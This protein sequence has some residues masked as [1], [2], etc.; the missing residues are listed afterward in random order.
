M[1]KELKAKWLEKLRSG[2]YKQTENSL[3]LIEE[4]ETFSYC[5]LGVLG[6]CLIDQ[7]PINHYWNSSNYFVSKELGVIE[8]GYL[9]KR[10]IPRNIQVLLAD[11]N[12]KGKSFLEI[13]DYIEEN[14]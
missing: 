10:V 9:G 13:A 6:E 14:L 7:D 1:N 11:M 5:C 12:D 3:R 4:D 2:K 8:G